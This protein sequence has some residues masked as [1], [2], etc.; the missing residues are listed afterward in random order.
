LKCHSRTEGLKLSVWI[1]MRISAV[2]PVSFRPVAACQMPSQSE[3]SFSAPA[4][5]TAS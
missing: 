1:G 4:L 3:F 2:Q 5:M